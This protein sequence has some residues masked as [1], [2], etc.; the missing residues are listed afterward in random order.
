V[1]Q[2][3]SRHWAFLGLAVVVVVSML[4]GIKPDVT[5]SADTIRMYEYLDSLP[6][7]SILMVSFDHE[8]SSIPEIAP[9]AVVFLRHAFENGHRLIGV[10]LLSEGT[11]VGYNLMAQAAD[12]SDKKY[13]TDYVYLGFRPQYIAAILSMGESISKTYPADYVGNDYD[14]L[15]LLKGV[16][17]YDDITGVV[18]IADGSL[19]THWMEYAGA[20]YGVQ[21]SAFVTAAMVTTYDPYLASGQMY[22]MVGGLRGAAGY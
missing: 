12:E 2:I 11:G 6:T 14:E 3:E 9:L 15:Q 1:K 18:S 13:G 22:A 17:N 21:V 10:S 19:T 20:R 8:A 5:P 4:L 7:G 16:G